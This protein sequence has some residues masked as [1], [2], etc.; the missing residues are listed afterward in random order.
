MNEETFYISDLGL[1]RSPD[2]Q[3][4]SVDD[5]KRSFKLNA[6]LEAEIP[7]LPK[8]SSVPSETSSEEYNSDEMDCSDLSETSNVSSIDCPRTTVTCLETYEELKERCELLGFRFNDCS[9][10]KEQMFHFDNC[11]DS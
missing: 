4:E 3:Q 10:G 8:L 1:F 6:F 11:F 2:T 9:E 7:K 5:S